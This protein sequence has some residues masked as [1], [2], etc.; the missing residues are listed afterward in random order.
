MFSRLGISLWGTALALAAG[1]AVGLGGFTFLYAEGLSY[2]SDAPAACANC[3]IMNDQHDGWQRS[4]H[5]GV[6]TCNDCH[7][8]HDFIGK[9]FSK[10]SNGFWHSKHFTLNDFHEPIR[11][12]PRNS[13]VLQANCIHCHEGV[14][15]DVVHLGS[16]GDPT[17]ACV[18]CHAHVGHAPTR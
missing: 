2:F 12:K 14:L 3:H 1:L 5:H 9:W 13:A 18:R 15:H 4:S 10:S 8:P 7:V 6:A 17:N 11:I 16:A